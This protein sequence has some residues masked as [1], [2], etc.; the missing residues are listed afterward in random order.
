MTNRAKM[1]TAYPP[2]HPMVQIDVMAV[3]TISSLSR[4]RPRRMAN[5]AEIHT[6][7]AGT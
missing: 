2:T 7:F 1:G 4:G 5:A 3:K 6:A